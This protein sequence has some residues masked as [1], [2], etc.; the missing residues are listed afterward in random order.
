[1]GDEGGTVDVHVRVGE[2]D[3]GEGAGGEETTADAE[4]SA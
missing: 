3:V 2:S 1:M 4:E